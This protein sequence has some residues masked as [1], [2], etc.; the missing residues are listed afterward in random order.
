MPRLCRRY[1]QFQT[2][3]LPTARWHG[4]REAFAAPS[5][6]GLVVDVREGDGGSTK[7]HALLALIGKA[8]ALEGCVPVRNATES[9]P[10]ARH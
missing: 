7:A 9:C 5:D 1:W 10:R 2:Y 3:W 4:A 8:Q 6:A